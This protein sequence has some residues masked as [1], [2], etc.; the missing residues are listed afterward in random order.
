MKR[1]SSAPR[2]P[3]V[4]AAKFRKAGAHKKSNKALRRSDKVKY[5][6]ALAEW[7][8]ICLLSRTRMG[9]NPSG[10]ASKMPTKAI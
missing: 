5:Q 6:G 4:S 1:K 7:S 8:G 10:S 2:N 9:S 3:F